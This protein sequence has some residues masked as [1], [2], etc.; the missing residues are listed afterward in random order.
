MQTD[1]EI[2]L[3]EFMPAFRAAAGRLMV[4]KYGIS[5]QK[6]ASLLNVTQAAIS[7][8]INERY[9]QSIKDAGQRINDEF[10]DTFVRKM[11]EEDNRNAQKTMCKACQK[12]HR[13]GCAIM[14]K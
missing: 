6:A 12:Y 9:S 8:Y 14:I 13:F 10:V 1:Y 7:K 5:Q 2:A 11:I 3:N 4:T